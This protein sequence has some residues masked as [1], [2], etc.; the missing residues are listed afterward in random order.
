M[1][2]NLR[3]AIAVAHVDELRRVA[4]HDRIR[5]H[6]APQRPVSAGRLMLAGHRVLA[7]ATRTTRSGSLKPSLS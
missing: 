4:D 1:N 5:A 7:V 6:L 3:Q 2:P